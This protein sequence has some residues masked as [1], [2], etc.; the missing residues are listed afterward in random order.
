MP[1]NPNGQIYRQPPR[2]NPR[3]YGNEEVARGLGQLGYTHIWVRA[4]DHPTTRRTV[5]TRGGHLRRMMVR[6][7]N[8]ITVYCST[9]RTA[10][11]Q[12]DIFLVVERSGRCRIMRD[13]E[14]C[15]R[16]GRGIELY[17]YP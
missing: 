7:D 12:G 6:T 3:T 16:N 11:R 15:D 2:S 4:C 5:A 10:N 14:H 9:G 13:S 8:H 1:A 17:R